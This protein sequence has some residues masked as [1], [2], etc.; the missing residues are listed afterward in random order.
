MEEDFTPLAID[1]EGTDGSGKR[2]TSEILKEYFEMTERPCKIISFPQ[3]DTLQ[4]NLVDEFLYRGLE[5]SGD[6]ILKSIREGLLYAVDRMVTLSKKNE[7]GKSLIDEYNEGTVLIFDRYVNSNFIHRTKTMESVELKDYIAVMEDIEYKY[8]N[9][10]KP[11]LVFVLK[12]EPEVSM[13][14]IIKRGRELDREEN[15]EC[16]T[17]AYNKIDELCDTQG[18]I[19]INCCEKIDDKFVM[20]NK[21]EIAMDVWKEIIRRTDI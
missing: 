9:I 7:N 17:K 19:K 8:M 15:I 3:H 2:T 20:K 18:F 16:L 1:I 13:E 4:G 11:D 12:V 14:N 10:I 6:G 5:F 21:T